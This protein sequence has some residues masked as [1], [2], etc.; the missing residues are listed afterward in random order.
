MA[1][2]TNQI[3]IAFNGEAFT[4]P[5]GCTIRQ[6]LEQLDLPPQAAVAVELN[7]EVIPRA[8]HDTCVLRAGDQVEV[9]TLVGG[10]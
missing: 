7:F 1:S 4:L 6:F 2:S 10:G 5:A 3:Q 8:E 9:V